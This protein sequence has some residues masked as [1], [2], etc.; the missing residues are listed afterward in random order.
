MT[1]DT[2]PHVDLDRFVH[3]RTLVEHRAGILRALGNPVRLRLIAVLCDR[4]CTVGELIARVELPQSSVSR[5]LA[6][7]RLHGLV[8]DH[9]HG[10]QRTY[11]LA[12][13][14]VVNLVRCLARC[15]HAPT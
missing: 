10:R 11:R 5:Q 3:D 8:T 14:E 15:G 2:T 1:S 6:W 9:I 7:L 12:I 4:D 13:P